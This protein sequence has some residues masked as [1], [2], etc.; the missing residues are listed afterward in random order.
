MQIAFPHRAGTAI[1]VRLQCGQTQLFQGRLGQLHGSAA[2]KIERRLL[3][4]DQHH[5][6]PATP[7]APAAAPAPAGEVAKTA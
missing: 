7:D 2:V 1:H 4:P 5:P 3:P 6:H